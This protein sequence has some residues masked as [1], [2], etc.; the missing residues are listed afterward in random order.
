MVEWNKKW[1]Q[2]LEL[3]LNELFLQQELWVRTNEQFV[4][5]ESV[6]AV[7]KKEYKKLKK[8]DEEFAT[9]FDK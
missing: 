1:I 3:K 7:L 6:L 9:N 5:N 2:I 8:L 4:H